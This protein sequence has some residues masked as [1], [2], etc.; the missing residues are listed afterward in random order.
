MLDE[1]ETQL[2][3]LFRNVDALDQLIVISLLEK[4]QKTAALGSFLQLVSSGVSGTNIESRPGCVQDKRA[5]LFVAGREKSH[6][7][8]QL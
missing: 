5:S 2:L 3:N 8:G 6:Q 1:Q 4:R 7:F